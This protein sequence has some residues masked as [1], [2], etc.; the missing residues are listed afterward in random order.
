ML[1][2]PKQCSV[3]K[4]YLLS[5]RERERYYHDYYTT[6]ELS[7]SPVKPQL[8]ATTVL[9]PCSLLPSFVEN[10]PSFIH[11]ELASCSLLY[12]EMFQLLTPKP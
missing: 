10:T 9:T 8:P 6:L 7:R 5:G 2:F 11:V 1:H 4:G 12:L 3:P